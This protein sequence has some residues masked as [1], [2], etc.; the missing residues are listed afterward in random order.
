MLGVS[1]FS[2]LNGIQKFIFYSKD[3]NPKYIPHEVASFIN[4]IDYFV[5]RQLWVYAIIK[6]FWPT[7]AHEEEDDNYREEVSL[8]E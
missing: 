7:K 4:F 2:S 3:C 6:S 8:L 5:T 1:T